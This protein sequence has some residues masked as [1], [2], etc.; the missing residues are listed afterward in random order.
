MLT[1]TGADGTQSAPLSEFFMDRYQTAC[2]REIEC[3]CDAFKTGA[4]NTPDGDDGLRSLLLADA[5][6]QSLQTTR[7]VQL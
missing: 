1:V 2:C 3:F 6:V 4:T 7:S 5:A